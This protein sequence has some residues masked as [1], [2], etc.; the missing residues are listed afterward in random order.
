MAKFLDIGGTD[1]TDI[2]SRK[3]NLQMSKSKL[4]K[5]TTF[6]QNN[7]NLN[8]LN[9]YIVYHYCFVCE[10]NSYRLPNCALLSYFQ[11]ISEYYTIS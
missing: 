9:V 10:S 2:Y 3:F 7:D 1:P 8:I 5:P 4:I 6:S 11:K